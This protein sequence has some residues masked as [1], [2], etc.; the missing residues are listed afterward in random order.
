MHA[1]TFR[2]SFGVAA[3]HVVPLATAP[4]ASC[5]SH[6]ALRIVIARRGYSR[7]CGCYFLGCVLVYA[8]FTTQIANVSGASNLR[9]ERNKEAARKELAEKMIHV[10]NREVEALSKDD[11]SGKSCG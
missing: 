5:L 4:I 10:T 6:P 2:Y 8:H 3:L 7:S 9:F 11:T 1:Y